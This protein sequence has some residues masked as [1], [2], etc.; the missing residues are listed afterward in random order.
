MN[1]KQYCKALW[2]KALYECNLFTI[3]PQVKKCGDTITVLVVDVETEEKYAQRKMPILPAMA[4]PCNLPHR[5][6]SLPVALGLQGYGF[7]LREETTSSGRPGGT[8]YR[9]TK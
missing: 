9:Q 5:A 8:N 7:L 2:I 1:V 3:Y 6:R 4:S